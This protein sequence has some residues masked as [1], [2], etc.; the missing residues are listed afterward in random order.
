MQFVV[1]IF[2]ILRTYIINLLLRN[3][4]RV[5]YKY[6]NNILQWIMKNFPFFF[7]TL[8]VGWFVGWWYFFINNNALKV[9][10]CGLKNTIRKVRNN[11]GGRQS[12]EKY[13]WTDKSGPLSKKKIPYLIENMCAPYAIYFKQSNIS[14]YLRLK[15]CFLLTFSVNITKEGLVVNVT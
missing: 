12:K 1:E 6:N 9:L 5:F 8:V 2:A 4:F 7:L 14:G 13:I 15:Y 3:I 11:N 10:E